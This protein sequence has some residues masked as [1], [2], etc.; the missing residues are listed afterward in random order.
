MTLRL[1]LTAPAAM[2]QATNTEARTLTGIA[3]PYG[4]AGATSAGRLTIDAGAVRIPDPLRRVK[5]LRE[6]DRAVSVGFATAA[7]D[8]PDHLT[9]TFGIARTPEGDTALLE[10]SEGVRDA[11]SVELDNVTIEAGH[12][13]AAD[14]TAV[15]QVAVPAFPS[16]VL[17]GSADPNPPPA[18][19]DPSPAPAPDP[20]ETEPD[21][22]EE[23]ETMPETETAAPLE[24]AAP[25]VSAARVTPP[26]E[27]RSSIGPRTVT[28]VAAALS[29]VLRGASD[30]GE[31]NQGIRAALADVTPGNAGTDQAFMRP[32]WLD[33]LWSPAAPTRR[34]VSAIGVSPLTSMTVEGWKWQTKPQVAPYA[35]NKAEI[36]T[37]PAVIEPA[38]ATAGRIAG[39]WD[40]DR[41]YLDF[42]TGFV[43][44][45][46]KAAT[47]DYVKKSE[48]YL[49]D[50][51]GAIA[52]PPA[53]PAQPGIISDATDLGAQASLTAGL[54]AI[55]TFVTS[56]GA[57]VHFIA[58]AAD[59]YSAFL[60]L[61]ETEVP[62]WLKSQSNVNLDG[63][64]SV[65]GITVAVDPGMASGRMLGGD[66]NSVSLWE[67]GPINVQAINLPNGGVD[68]AL[69]GYHANMVHDP[70]GLARCDVTVTGSATASTSTARKA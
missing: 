12:V 40:L 64:A 69:F 31:A 46:L 5:L 59:V 24:T 33:E 35:G 52:G 10:A 45:F 30:A 47:A 6:H 11:L 8:G 51:H 21:E 17:T 20:E 67:T 4:E 1:T 32:T 56:N 62:W 44:A 68:L 55:V 7:A 29:G 23:T 34:L 60:N 70:A 18:D 27:R 13:T 54:E 28:E 61:P 9:M 63:S 38:T 53:V 57:S 15:G 66:R 42:P 58:M 37:N 39:G 26:V 49:I 48:T 19:P 2:V 22:T 36:P 41:I 25:E 14:L 16:A 65:A 43:Q 3:L 50:G